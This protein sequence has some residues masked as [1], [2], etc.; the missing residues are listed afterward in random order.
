MLLDDPERLNWHMAY[1]NHIMHAGYTDVLQQAEVYR[2]IT[3]ERIME[4]ARE[5]FVP[6]HLVCVVQSSIPGIEK[7]KFRKH[8]LSL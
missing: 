3:P 4:I 2:K 8:I 6:S 5:V 7:R 1:E